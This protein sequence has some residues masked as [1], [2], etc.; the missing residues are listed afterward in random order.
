MKKII[1]TAIILAALGTTAFVVMP[2]LA[3]ESKP[4]VE[5][6]K[7]TSA[8]FLKE[9]GFVNARGV[10]ADRAKQDRDFWMKTYGLNIIPEGELF[11]FL[12]SNGFVMAPADRY[13]GEVPEF[14]A[15]QMEMNYQAINKHL[16][17]GYIEECDL[18]ITGQFLTNAD[19]LPSAPK[20]GMWPRIKVADYLT[21]DAIERLGLSKEK[22]YGIYA[23][24]SI[25]NFQ[26]GR[27][28]GFPDNSIQVMAP[29]TKFNLQGMQIIGRV[30][31]INTDPITVVKVQDNW[32]ILA[33]W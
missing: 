20:Q 3:P 32:V 30:A 23:V 4:T 13:T 7:K 27:L 18:T 21:T 5:Q 9:M 6:E 17:Y 10:K 28:G 11:D 29:Y 16:I 25:Y 1:I 26:A 19:M 2:S 33:Q 22:E 12:Q 8:D 24:G 14:A 31:S 15:A